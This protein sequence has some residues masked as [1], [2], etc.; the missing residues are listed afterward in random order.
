M[1]SPVVLFGPQLKEHPLRI[2]YCPKGHR[3]KFLTFGWEL[4][5]QPAWDAPP[6]S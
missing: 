2:Y 1:S 5:K 6:E 3:E 4:L